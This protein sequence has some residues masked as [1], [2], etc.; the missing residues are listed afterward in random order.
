MTIMRLW[1]R[2]Y[3]CR[4]GLRF[5]SLI[6]DNYCRLLDGV[7]WATRVYKC[8]GDHSN[9][10]TRYIVWY[11]HFTEFIWNAELHYQ[12]LV[13]F[14]DL[15]F[16][17]TAKLQS[18]YGKLNHPLST[19]CLLPCPKTFHF[20]HTLFDTRDAHVYILIFKCKSGHRR[21]RMLHFNLNYTT[22]WVYKTIAM[23]CRILCTL[24]TL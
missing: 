9:I 23:L 19:L 6:T 18:L 13:L 5:L 21:R 20:T 17:K 8:K 2:F 3:V 1:F 11:P 16:P 15:S 22:K 24:H 7:F 14:R 10:I 12:K 4:R